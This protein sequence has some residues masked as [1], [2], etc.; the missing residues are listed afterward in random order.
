MKC[1]YPKN[2]VAVDEE[3]LKQ[4][5]ALKRVKTLCLRKNAHVVRVAVSRF[6]NSV[7]NAQGAQEIAL[8]REEA[9]CKI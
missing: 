8:E 6:L 4:I 3:T 9:P 2:A 1:K 7:K 5:E